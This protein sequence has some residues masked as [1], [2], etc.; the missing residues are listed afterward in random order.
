[1]THMGQLRQ[2]FS[3]KLSLDI[4]LKV[5]R[6]AICSLFTYGSEAWKLDERTRAALNGANAPC[7]SHITGHSIHEEAST[8][9]RTFDL[10]EAIRRTRARW[11]G[12]ILRMGPKRMIY[13]T[14][15]R[16]H[17]M[18]HEGN[19]FA[20][21]SH[22]L[23]LVQIIELAQDRDEWKKVMASHIPQEK[24]SATPSRT[25]GRWFGHG[26]DTVWIGPEPHIPPTSAEITSTEKSQRSHH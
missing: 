26:L 22:N 13:H 25:Q 18:N 19:L 17:E 1:M 16:Q 7:L 4:K 10:V 8:R 21:V 9:T 20:D 15:I 6:A 5:Y 12:H 23:S 3:I 11:L 24:S 14:V 2:V